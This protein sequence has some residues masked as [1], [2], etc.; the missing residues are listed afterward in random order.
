LKE[1]FK[2]WYWARNTTTTYKI[3]NHRQAAQDTSVS[4]NTPA[5]NIW[6]VRTNTTRTAKELSY[7]I[8]LLTALHNKWTDIAQNLIKYITLRAS[9]CFDLLEGFITVD[10]GER[11][12]TKFQILTPVLQKVQLFWGAALCRLVN[13]YR[14]FEGSYCFHLQG[15][16]VQK[17]GGHESV[18]RQVCCT[19]LLLIEHLFDCTPS[20]CQK[21]V[22]P[23]I[24]SVLIFSRDAHDYRVVGAVEGSHSFIKSFCTQ[25]INLQSGSALFF[26]ST[27]FFFKIIHYWE[28]KE[29]FDSLYNFR[30]KHFSF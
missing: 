25:K 18:G 17:N 29:Y 6:C 14:R 13:S 16:E 27:T 12:W 7:I 10:C 8:Q 5:Y 11:K 26:H 28:W 20:F 9:T 24:C 30:L 2:L 23:E 3:K 4:N 21:A 1:V 22:F 19:D 15:Q